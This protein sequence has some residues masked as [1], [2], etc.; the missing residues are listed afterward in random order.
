VEARRRHTDEADREAA[1]TE[2]RWPAVIAVLVALALYAF[3]PSSFLPALRYSVVAVCLALLV[4]LVIINPVRMK[5]ERPWSRRLSIALT[6]VL[7]VANTVALVQLITQLLQVS[8]DADGTLLIAAAQVWS[9]NVIVFALIYWEMDRGGPVI[10]TSSARRDLPQADIRFPQDE[11]AD[12]VIEVARGSSQKANWTASF[13][14]Y[15]Y[16]SA[17]NAMAF[18]PPDAMPLSTRSKVLVGLQALAAYV[19]LVLVIA[20]AVALLG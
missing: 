18:S 2:H 4:P 13:I 9:T 16:F 12:N 8:S 17:S 14:D 20:R 3:L 10:R 19:I 1:R 11:N 7:A 15:L 5:E 6:I